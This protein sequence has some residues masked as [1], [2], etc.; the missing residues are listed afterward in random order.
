MATEFNQL[1]SH[2]DSQTFLL[3]LFKKAE[4]YLNY[5]TPI[6]PTLNQTTGLF[7]LA[8]DG[9]FYDST[10]NTTHISSNYATSFPDRLSPGE[11][12]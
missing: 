1:I 6:A 5:T 10:H 7:T 11:S 4:V 9:L 8:L 2:H 12:E 3:D